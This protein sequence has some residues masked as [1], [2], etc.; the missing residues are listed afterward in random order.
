MLTILPPNFTF[1]I[2]L[3]CGISDEQLKS[4]NGDNTSIK[5]ISLPSKGISS[6]KN[7]KEQAIEGFKEPL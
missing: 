7:L 5:N 4:N 1:E 3:D 2:W 6:Y